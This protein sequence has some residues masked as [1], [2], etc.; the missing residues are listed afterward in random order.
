MKNCII[1]FN[2]LL[3][4]YIL[5]MFDFKNQY[6]NLFNVKN[7]IKS[8]FAAICNMYSIIHCKIQLICLI[9]SQKLLTV[10]LLITCYI[11]ASYLSLIKSLL[12]ISF[13]LMI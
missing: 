9:N 3:K 4:R 2:N 13:I 6:D 1:K 5:C 11:Y 7:Q 12:L 10:K 8:I